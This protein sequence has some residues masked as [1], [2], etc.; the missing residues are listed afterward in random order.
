MTPLEKHKAL[1]I[2]ANKR[3]NLGDVPYEC[4]DDR[5]IVLFAVSVKNSTC[6]MQ[7]ID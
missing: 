7:A 4:R 2:L 3:N 1:K 5:D 6:F